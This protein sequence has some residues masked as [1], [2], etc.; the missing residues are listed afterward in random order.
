MENDIENKYTELVIH[1][2]SDRNRLE[3]IPYMDSM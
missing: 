2:S 1:L 3:Y